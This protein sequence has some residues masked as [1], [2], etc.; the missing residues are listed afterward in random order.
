M[1]SDKSEHPDTAILRRAGNSKFLLP[2]FGYAIDNVT[3]SSRG[4]QFKSGNTVRKNI[5]SHRTLPSINVFVQ[6]VQANAKDIE[7]RRTRDGRFFVGMRL[8]KTDAG[9][10][11]Q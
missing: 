8:K 9:H 5:P 4:I 7:Y 6:R 2:L 1:S 11:R 3:H 10:F